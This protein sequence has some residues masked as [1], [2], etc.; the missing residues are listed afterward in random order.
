ME[1]IYENLILGGH[2]MPYTHWV[3]DIFAEL[4]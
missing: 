4:N 3:V 2:T 1:K